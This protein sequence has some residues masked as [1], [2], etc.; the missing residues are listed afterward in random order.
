[1]TT[2]PDPTQPAPEPLVEEPLPPR[3]ALY[4]AKNISTLRLGEVPAEALNLNVAGRRVVGP[5]QGFGKLWQKTY[6]VQLT[7]L[8]T[9]PAEVIAAWKQHFPQFWPTGNRFY[10]PLTG[11]APGE[12]ALINSIGPGGLRLSTGIFVLYADDESFTFMT[13]QGHLFAGWVT[14]SAADRDGHTLAQA[15]ILM[16]ANDPL[17]ELAMPLGLH[18]VEDKIW[19][20]TLTGLA[21]HLGVTN[22]VVESAAVCVDRRRQWANAKNLRHNAA[23]RSGLHAIA[24]PLRWLARPQSATRF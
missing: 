1:M 7:G 20:Q 16:R 5:V 4:W 9:T 17:Y 11:I 24:A 3:E 12:V 6:R 19:R 13:P 14:F 23:I 21:A 10:G 22:P 8:Q 15:Q 2:P 18:R